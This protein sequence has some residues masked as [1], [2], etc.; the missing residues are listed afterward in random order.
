MKLKR[1]LILFVAVCL[2]TA[3]NSAWAEEEEQG[4]FIS[5]VSLGSVNANQTTE[6]YVQ[7]IDRS[8]G[9]D[10]D[11]SGL[12]LADAEVTVTMTLGTLVIAEALVLSEEGYKGS[13]T[14]PEAG[15]WEI[16]VRAVGQNEYAG[17]EDVVDMTLKVNPA[18]SNLSYLWGFLMVLFAAGI[19]YIL[20]RIRRLTRKQK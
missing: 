20:L 2:L 3:A 14:F 6:Y 8:V 13:I 18:G 9:P 5:R 11:V 16:V 1:Y 17:Y 10:A 4:I 19:V 7:V 12:A 15:D